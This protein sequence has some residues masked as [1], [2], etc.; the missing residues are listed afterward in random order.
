MNLYSI[1]KII[2]KNKSYNPVYDMND[3]KQ[4]KL[5]W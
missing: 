1:L 5:L 3:L 4:K 2:V